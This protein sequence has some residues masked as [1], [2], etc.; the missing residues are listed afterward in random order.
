MAESRLCEEMEGGGGGL[1]TSTETLP[2]SFSSVEFAM[3]A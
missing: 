3:S 2:T 1:R